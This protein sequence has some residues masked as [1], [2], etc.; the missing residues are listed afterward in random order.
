M[1]HLP[2]HVRAKLTAEMIAKIDR[3]RE[4]EEA[5]K[6]KKAKKATKTKKA[7]SADERTVA[8]YVRKD[9]AGP[10]KGVQLPLS[11]V[12]NGTVRV[13]VGLEGEGLGKVTVRAM[14]DF[15][16]LAKASAK[17]MR[18]TDKLRG[19]VVKALL[20]AAA[21]VPAGHQGHG[22]TS[23][24]H[25]GKGGAYTRYALQYARTDLFFKHFD[26]KQREEFYALARPLHP[27]HVADALRK[28]ADFHGVVGTARFDI[29]HPTPV[30]NYAGTWDVLGIRATLRYDNKL[31]YTQI[32]RHRGQ[33]S[34]TVNE[35]PPHIGTD[36]P[37]M[38]EV[39]VLVPRDW[40]HSE[41]NIILSNSEPHD[42]RLTPN[43]DADPY[44]GE[45]EYEARERASL[46]EY[47]D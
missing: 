10:Y 29:Y 44:I 27:S 46:H 9:N 3:M 20:E 38:F 15:V 12:F 33:K 26:T 21:N 19:A 35:V 37:K 2:A 22:W 13:D 41:S 7:V 14:S 28:V 6:P 23:G 5:P 16:P 32:Q 36:I 40:D 34:L 11:L 42:A 17:A 30:V 25:L 18:S 24:M 31:S 8:G 4:E 45:L 43:V 1:S 47:D 39:A